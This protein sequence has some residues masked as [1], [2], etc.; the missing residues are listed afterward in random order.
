MSLTAG[1]MLQAGPPE[2]FPVDLLLTVFSALTH[3]RD[4]L[5]CACV[6]KA[7]RIGRAKALLPKLAVDCDGSNWLLKL[8][9][10]QLAAVRD[11]CMGFNSTPRGFKR[12]CHAPGLCL[13][14]PIIAAAAELHWNGP[15]QSGRFGQ[16]GAHL[17][18]DRS[19]TAR[20]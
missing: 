10:V 9:P 3:P 7:W 13:W 6:C 1:S 14:P 8:N 16:V 5:V 2:N 15:R 19:C 12:Q 20:P 17:M 18:L 11:V 4:L